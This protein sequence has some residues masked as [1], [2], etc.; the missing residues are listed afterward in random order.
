[1]PEEHHEHREDHDHHEYS[2]FVDGVRYT[3][4][5]SAVTGQYIISHIPNFEPG[6]SLYLEGHGDQSDE[7]ITESTT[8]DLRDG[9]KHFYTMPPASFGAK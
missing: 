2:Y 3:T 7:L 5:N 4:E 6:Y 1:M 8:V 9:E